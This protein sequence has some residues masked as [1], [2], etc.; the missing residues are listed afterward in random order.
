MVF[1]THFGSVLSFKL[2]PSALTTSIEEEPGLRSSR[3]TLPAV[4]PVFRRGPQRVPD[5][6]FCLD[7][8]LLC[9]KLGH[10]MLRFSFTS[11]SDTIKEKGWVSLTTGS[12]LLIEGASGFTFYTPPNFVFCFHLTAIRGNG[13]SKVRQGSKVYWSHSLNKTSTDLN[14]KETRFSS[15]GHAFRTQRSK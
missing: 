12:I 5:F 9:L 14:S 2:I 13:A 11:A 1:Q 15:Q 3:Q 4:S 8:Q 6:S 10:P 7:V